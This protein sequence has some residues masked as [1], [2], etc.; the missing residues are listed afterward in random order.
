[1]CAGL[2]VSD[3][4]CQYFSFGTDG[5]MCKHLP[6]AHFL[7]PGRQTGIVA[8]GLRFVTEGVLADLEPVR[9][10][11]GRAGRRSLRLRQGR[12]TPALPNLIE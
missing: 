12:V 5:V 1:V 6:A 9:D 11:A 4:A 8:P 10:D 2:F 3:D 7:K